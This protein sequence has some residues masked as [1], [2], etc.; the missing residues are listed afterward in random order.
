MFAIARS[1][2]MQSSR[3]RGVA[4]RR[5]CPIARSLCTRFLAL[6]DLRQQRHRVCHY[7][8]NR[9]YPSIFQSV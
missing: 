4:D 1:D 8:R 2:W 7:R 3:D 9:S 6:H 5:I